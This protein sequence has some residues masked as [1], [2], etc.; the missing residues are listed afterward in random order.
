MI[1]Y[2]Y[3]TVVVSGNDLDETGERLSQKLNALGKQGWKLESIISQPCLG[4][5]SMAVLGISQKNTLIFMRQTE[6]NA[7]GKYKFLLD[8]PS[9]ISYQQ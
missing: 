3:L 5:S 7:D 9:N 4:S 1:S 6:Q 2:E 8:S